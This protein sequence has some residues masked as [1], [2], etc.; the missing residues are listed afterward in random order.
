LIPRSN[1]QRDRLNPTITDLTQAIEQEVE[2][3]QQV[4]RLMTHP[5]VGPLTVLA[6]VLIIAPAERFQCGKQLQ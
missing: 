5:G 6:F 4:Q 2:K 1:G 3:C